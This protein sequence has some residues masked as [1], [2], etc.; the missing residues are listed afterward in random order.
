MEVK[1]CITCGKKLPLTIEY[2]GKAKTNRDGFKGE[3]KQC[4]TISERAYREK[5]KERLSEH[6]K[7]YNKNNRDKANIRSRRYCES[8]K[9]SISEHKSSYY[10]E[11]KEWITERNEK[12]RQYNSDKRSEYSKTY[13]ERNKDKILKYC[14]KYREENKEKI[15]GNRK[16]Y[17]EENI[18]KIKDIC[19]KYREENPEKIRESRRKYKK[20]NVDKCCIYTQKRIAKKLLLPNTLTLKQ[21]E[22]I[23]L[24]FD[25]KCAYCGK[26]LILQQ[27]HF[28]PVAKG[29]EYT[30]N[31][32]I[33][34]CRSCN[35]SKGAK[36][37]F[38]WYP[39]FKNYSKKREKF[40][41]KYLNY[42]DNI[43]QLKMM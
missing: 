28:I 41:L 27:E 14:K 38:E 12:Y 11:N 15:N 34:S 32:I 16:K 20:N 5:N 40:I 7:E 30:H 8:H 33:P 10:Q 3:C 43:Q 9:E 39:K 36:D 26:E 13:C 18:E 2:F 25:N 42:K 37:F 17:R 4:K 1:I 19:R 21:W 31:N 35:C 6:K 22:E 24:Q 29:G 23:K